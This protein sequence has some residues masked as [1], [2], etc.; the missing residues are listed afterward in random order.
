MAEVLWL[1]AHASPPRPGDPSPPPAS[2]PPADDQ[3]GSTRHTA[4][5]SDSA[6][7]PL[8]PAHPASPPS[9]TA[10]TEDAADR[11]RARGRGARIRSAAPL[12]QPL[13][14]ARSLR[15]F[16]R[17]WPNGRHR[18]LDIDATVRAYTRTWQLIPW[19]QPTPEPWFE[20]V[21][22]VDDSPSM[23]I[24]D[25]EVAKL[26]TTFQRL[27][28]FHDVRAWRMTVHADGVTLHDR[29]GRPVAASQPPA[30][31]RR[32]LII[33]VTDGAAP[34]WSRPGVWRTV[35]AWAAS[36]PTSLI[37][38]LPARL[39]A[40]T[41]LNQPAVRVRALTPG[42]PNPALR[43]AVPWQLD[44]L[45]E[46]WIAVPAAP[47]SRYA[48]GRW[49]RTLMRGDPHGCDAF[50]VPTAGRPHHDGEDT[51]DTS[52]AP[53]PPRGADLVAAFRRTATPQAV[54]LAVLSSPF[55]QISLPPLHLLRQ[56]M[57]PAAAVGDVAEVVISGLFVHTPEGAL[58]HR[59]GVREALRKLISETDILQVYAVLRRH[60]TARAG[61][62]T[63]PAVLEDPHADAVL[64][65]DLRPFIRASRDTLAYLAAPPGKNPTAAAA[66]APAGPPAPRL[67]QVIPPQLAPP[68]QTPAPSGL[69]NLPAP[70]T[71]FVGRATELALLH[72]S[73]DVPGAGATSVVH[74][75][76][77]IGKSAL[78]L[79]H[80]HRHADSGGLVWWMTADSPESVE[81]GLIALAAA[82]R[83][84]SATQ[85]AEATQWAVGWLAHHDGWLLVLDHVTDHRDIDHLLT[86]PTSGHIII[87]SRLSAPWGE[88]ISQVIRLPEL[89]AA[90][91]VRL[92][93]HHSG[94]T[95]NVPDTGPLAALAALALELGHLPLAIT[96]AGQYLRQ[97]HIAPSDYLERFRRKPANVLGALQA[98]GQSMVRV[99]WQET[100]SML[101]EVS[102]AAPLL[103]ILSWFGP[104]PIPRSFLGS[105][106]ETGG[107]SRALEILAGH[108][109]VTLTD[110]DIAVNRLMQTIARTPDPADPYRSQPEIAAARSAATA[111]L[112]AA[113]PAEPPPSSWPFWPELVTHIE[114]LAA[115]APA[116]TDINSTALA[117]LLALA[118][119]FHESQRRPQNAL[120]DFEGAHS[121]YQRILGPDDPRTA[122]TAISRQRVLAGMGMRR[123]G[124]AQILIDHRPVANGVLISARYILTCAHALPAAAEVVIYFA[125]DGTPQP[126]RVVF[127]APWRVSDERVPEGTFGVPDVAVV[128]L[129]TPV[130]TPPV[131]LGSPNARTPADLTCVSIA[132]GTVTLTPIK[133]NPDARI[134]ELIRFDGGPGFADLRPGASG[135]GIFIPRSQQLC[136][137]LTGRGPDDTGTMLP[138]TAVRRYWEPID[139]LLPLDWLTAKDRRRL[140]A[141][142][143]QMPNLGALTSAFQRSF[144]YV[145][146]QLDFRTPWDGV[147][148]V[149]E[150]LLIGDPSSPATYAPLR[151]WLLLL[152]DMAPEGLA[153]DLRAFI[154]R[155]IPHSVELDRRLSHRLL[156]VTID[157]FADGDYRLA[158][159]LHEPSAE[160]WDLVAPMRPSPRKMIKE[161]V[162]AVIAE[163]LAE[164]WRPDS[165]PELSLEFSVPQSLL[166][167][168][169][170]KL[171]L[172]SLSADND[173]GPGGLLG[174]RFV[175]TVRPTERRSPAIARDL[176]LHR[177]NLSIRDPRNP[178]VLHIT[179]S[180]QASSEILRSLEHDETAVLV[181]LAPPRKDV[182]RAAIAAGVPVMIWPRTN[183][184]PEQAAITIQSFTEKPLNEWP[185]ALRILRAKAFQAERSPMAA[186][187]I[188]LLWDNP[189]MIPDPPLT[190]EL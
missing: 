109:L 63:F 77:G 147:R 65:D 175:V 133:A 130:S 120:D 179:D 110:S 70:A 127:R 176:L 108:N 140:R 121:M 134:G 172:D 185:T 61:S 31:G 91:A 111:L 165:D 154:D 35:R 112:A 157:R 158:A 94:L 102:I 32:R 21:L 137:I 29:A 186:R 48:L 173:V 78:A 19:F 87:T 15:P 95:M 1:A 23:R 93:A 103:R 138:I 53:A 155:A 118:G 146:P 119:H 13:H 141:L 82:L 10:D 54:R 159:Y 148:Y 28:A 169:F 12:S 39:W 131:Q 74:G 180:S 125:D 85:A 81:A 34:G 27:G 189:H 164:T 11:T 178:R 100:L 44:D 76:A 24:W 25:Q 190:A 47:V 132:D 151:Q 92:L 8:S 30:G 69:A 45:H 7:R 124:L 51:D 171:A 33:F 86:Q 37:S 126:G 42:S 167:Y 68:D 162:S 49:A 96:S 38:P 43:F 104:D 142:I 143:T 129:T 16:K 20:V 161:T 163:S 152:A 5:A 17:R 55:E 18:R 149:A 3:V 64:P 97:T 153:D 182:L 166:S 75:L 114:A 71:P 144:P 183:D 116:D 107:L 67:H 188:T 50:L 6:A 99:L 187:E 168:P 128:E 106:G 98:A 88:Q 113:S 101:P 2:A 60:V 115:H 9:G 170:D 66:A 46:Q 26:K 177:W 72:S 79:Q 156:H 36:T 84:A 90:D 160:S 122:E 58:R 73:P 57:V 83:P 145:A 52:A 14:I 4:V 89:P 22:V 139:D 56:E 136:A 40:R 80:A 123:S 174:T 105:S 62:A 150:E 184:H 135:A 181:F 41:G 117:D 59:G